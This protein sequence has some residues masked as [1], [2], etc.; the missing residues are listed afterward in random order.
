M[1]LFPLAG[2]I[3]FLALF[4]LATWFRLRLPR[5]VSDGEPF[6]QILVDVAVFT[7]LLYFAGGAANPF[8]GMYVLPLTIA[9]AALPWVYTWSV[10]AATGACY[11]LLMFLNTPLMHASGEPVRYTFQFAAMGINFVITGGC[12]AYFVVSI[13]SALRKH[14]R[15]LARAKQNELNNERIV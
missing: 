15:L 3:G 10:A 1:P 11:L 6:A 14:E 13:T 5:P 12:I 4:N 7:V 9:A 2:G 8:A